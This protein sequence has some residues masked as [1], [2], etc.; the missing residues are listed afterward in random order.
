VHPSPPPKQV[1]MAPTASSDKPAWHKKAMK[2][3]SDKEEKKKHKK[4]DQELATTED[5]LLLDTAQHKKRRH[6]DSHEEKREGKKFEREGKSVE[7]E[8]ADERDA[9]MKRAMEDEWFTVART[10][11]RFRLIQKKDAK[12]VL[13]SRFSSIN[14]GPQALI[15]GVDEADELKKV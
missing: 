5:A 8:A 10:D 4:N 7:V 11:P 15:C 13:D 3:K 9:K 12:V 2:L 6:K 14:D 1:T